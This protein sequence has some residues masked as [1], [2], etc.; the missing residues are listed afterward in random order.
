MRPFIT[1]LLVLTALLVTTRGIAQTGV[2][3]TAHYPVTTD[4]VGV[5]V[6]ILE[7]ISQLENTLFSNLSDIPAQAEQQAKA[8]MQ[9]PDWKKQEARLTRAYQELTDAWTL[10]ITKVPAVVFDNTFVVYG[11]TDITQAQQQL[12]IWQEQHP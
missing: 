10:G 5:Q 11:T 2:Y 8:Y 9:Q 4:S 3:T 6:H 1:S 12:D 7:D